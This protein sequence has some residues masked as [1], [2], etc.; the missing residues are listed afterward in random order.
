MKLIKNILNRIGSL[1]SRKKKK[2]IIHGCDTVCF[3]RHAARCP[4]YEAEVSIDD[5][6]IGGKIGACIAHYHINILETIDKFTEI[7]PDKDDG[8]G[9]FWSLITSYTNLELARINEGTSKP[10]WKS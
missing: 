7:A 10:L 8:H 6:E 2:F 3:D 9:E 1:F 4:Y 5:P